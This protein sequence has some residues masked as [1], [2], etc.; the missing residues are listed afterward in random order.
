MRKID[1]AI[2]I[3]G[4]HTKRVNAEETRHMDSETLEDAHKQGPTQEAPFANVAHVHNPRFFINNQSLQ[5]R[6]NRG[7]W[8]TYSS[9]LATFT[10]GRTGNAKSTRHRTSECLLFSPAYK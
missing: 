6:S 9:S 3:L 7:A 8:L 5:V 2:N 10:R 1:Q 4:R